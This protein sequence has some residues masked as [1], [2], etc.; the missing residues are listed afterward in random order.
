MDGI[1][2]KIAVVVGI[3]VFYFIFIRDILFVIYSKKYILYTN[4]Q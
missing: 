2:G 4:R 1:K 3:I